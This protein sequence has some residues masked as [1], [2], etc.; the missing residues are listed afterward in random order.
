MRFFSFI[1]SVMFIV[2]FCGCAG[3]QSGVLSDYP[4]WVN[5]AGGVYKGE[6]G[7]TAIFAVGGYEVVGSRSFAFT[8]AEADGRNKIARIME[9]HVTNMFESYQREAGDRF[10]SETISSVFNFEEV[11]RQ[12]AKQSISGAR[13]I[14]TYQHP[15]EKTLYV[16]MRLD[17]NAYYNSVSEKARKMAYREGFAKYTKEQKDALL[18]KMDEVLEKQAQNEHPVFNTN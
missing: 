7:K 12:T 11:S 3:Q 6:D 14:K 5:E 8:G 9:T 17:L 18:D 1:F 4:D 2:T 13:R 15:G 10:D 16:L